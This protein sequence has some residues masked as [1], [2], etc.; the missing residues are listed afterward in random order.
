LQDIGKGLGVCGCKIRR[1]TPRIE[2]LTDELKV[3]IGEIRKIYCTFGKDC[4]SIESIQ[5]EILV[6]FEEKWLSKSVAFVGAT[7]TTVR[8]ESSHS[9]KLLRF[10]RL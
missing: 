3:F 2:H 9:G 5:I 7:T 4:A 1:P 10:L 6:A 8:A